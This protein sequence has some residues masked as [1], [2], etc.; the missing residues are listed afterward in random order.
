MGAGCLRLDLISI[1][2]PSLFS[3]GVGGGSGG[4]TRYNTVLLILPGASAAHLACIYRRE[5]ERGGDGWLGSQS[6]VSPCVL[7]LGLP[8]LYGPP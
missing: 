4:S 2:A 6:P 8:F 3:G 1:H 7:C 5:R